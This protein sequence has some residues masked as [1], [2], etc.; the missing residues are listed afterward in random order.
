MYYV[1]YYT[2]NN[3]EARWFHQYLKIRAKVK[4]IAGNMLT[5][6]HETVADV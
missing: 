1:K 5:K 4:V 6:A 2:L 3:K